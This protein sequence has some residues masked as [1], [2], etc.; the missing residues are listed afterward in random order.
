[1]F[2]RSVYQIGAYMSQRDRVRRV[3]TKRE[4]LAEWRGGYLP[5]VREVY[6]TDGVP[7]YPARSESWSNYVDN[8][9]REG[10]VSDHQAKTWSQPPECSR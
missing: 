4:A 5:S 6:E 3:T 9:H 1:M 10:L 2:G 7:D 8:L